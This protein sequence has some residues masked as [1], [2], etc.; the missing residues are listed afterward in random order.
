[1]PE[2]DDFIR[3]HL[4]PRLQQLDRLSAEAAAEL[5]ADIIR[6]LETG[7]G[8]EAGRRCLFLALFML[9]PE[10][11]GEIERIVGR[12]VARRGSDLTAEECEKLA[13]V[14]FRKTRI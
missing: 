12:P 10:S 5:R 11:Q 1:M 2:I 9:R 6:R 4:F 13:E 14:I 7:L 8:E 3:R